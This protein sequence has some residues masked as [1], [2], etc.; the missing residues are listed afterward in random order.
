M[1]APMSPGRLH[2]HVHGEAFCHMRYAND[3]R[4]VVRSIWNSRDG[5]TPFGCTDPDN[6]GVELR[7]VDWGADRYDP[8]HVPAVGDLVWIDLH[9][10]RAAQLAARQVDAWWDSPTMPMSKVFDSKADAIQV[11]VRGYFESRGIDGD[12][13]DLKP[14]DL[15]RAT[16]P[17]IDAL[18]EERSTESSAGATC[19]SCSHRESAVGADA[20][21]R[22]TAA[23]QAHVAAEHPEVHP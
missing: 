5:V 22:V 19:N 1:T 13:V 11:L 21:Q 18:L 4:T 15:V 16:E 20:L 2:G 8:L 3:D 9:P 23:M 10:E 6:T 14:P 7:H 17:F 12:V